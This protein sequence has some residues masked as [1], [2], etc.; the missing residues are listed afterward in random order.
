MVSFY[1]ER[2]G[3]KC[4]LEYGDK[5]DHNKWAKADKSMLN[6]SGEKINKV[7]WVE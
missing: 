6:S 5:F 4:I 1:K 2:D 3:D 7:F